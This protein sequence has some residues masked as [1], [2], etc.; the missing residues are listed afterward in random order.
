MGGRPAAPPRHPRWMKSVRAALEESKGF[1]PSGGCSPLRY[2]FRDCLIALGITTLRV[3]FNW[4]GRTA[5]SARSH[6]VLRHRTAA[7]PG[8]EREIRTPVLSGHRLSRSAASANTQAL[9]SDPLSTSLSGLGG[10]SNL[11]RGDRIRTCTVNDTWF[12]ARRAA[13]CPT[14]RFDG[15]Y[16]CKVR[17][18]SVNSPRRLVVKGQGVRPYC[19]SQPHRTSWGTCCRLLRAVLTA[20]TAAVVREGFEPSHTGLKVQR[21]TLSL[22]DRASA[23]AQ[24]AACVGPRCPPCQVGLGTAPRL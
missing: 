22:T 10:G 6:N 12:T 18:S 15:A 3:L 21:P 13:N 9:S 20:G 7:R 17:H 24:V 23:S 4:S 16:L 5:T 8:G 11:S 19:P 1:E 2:S 14:P